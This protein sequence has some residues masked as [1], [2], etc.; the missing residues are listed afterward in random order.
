MK[1]EGRQYTRDDIIKILDNYITAQERRWGEDCIY[2]KWAKEAKIKKL[3]DYDAGK[4]IEV[5]REE[6]HEGGMDYCDYFMSDGSVLT[7]NFGYT[8]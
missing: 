8:D 4:V 5:E 2:T 6:Y 7:S 3:A 1:K